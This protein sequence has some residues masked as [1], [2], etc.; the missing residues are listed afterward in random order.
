MK[1]PHNL[2]DPEDLLHFVELDNFVDEWKACKLDVE[3]DLGEL[4]IGIMA[5][6]KAAPVIK[7]TGGL[8]K[9]R[10][11]PRKM[12]IGKRGAF[13]VCYVYFEEHWTIMLV[14]V[15]KKGRSDD[16]DADDKKAIRT[17]IAEIEK[18]LDERS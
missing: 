7:G 14:T 2:L 13:R 1:D 11:S 15:Y 9:L 17:I 12:S 5:N 3:A 10:Y 18:Y 16:L 6:P 8:R 4:M